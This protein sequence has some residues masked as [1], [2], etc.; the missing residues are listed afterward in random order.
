[1]GTGSTNVTINTA[2]SLHAALEARG[3][4]GYVVG[5]SRVIRSPDRR[6]FILSDHCTTRDIVDIVNQW[7]PLPLPDHREN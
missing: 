6:L 1:M 4:D 3:W 7:Q 5:R 2:D